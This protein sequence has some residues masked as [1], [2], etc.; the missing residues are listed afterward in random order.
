[1][2]LCELQ[3]KQNSVSNTLHLSSQSH[4]SVP[5]Q[6][7]KINSKYYYLK[8]LF[9]FIKNSITLRIKVSIESKKIV[10]NSSDKKFVKQIFGS[11]L[12][13]IFEFEFRHSSS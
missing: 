11:F 7:V 9:R 4:V 5:P 2:N 3:L 6:N 8:L 1:M 10:V 12:I 13:C